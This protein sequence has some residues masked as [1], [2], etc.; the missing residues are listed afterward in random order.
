MPKPNHQTRKKAPVGLLNTFSSLLLQIVTIISGFIIP[1]LILSTFG[2]ETNGLVSSLNQ[3]LNY[4]SLLEGGL[5]SVITASLYKPLIHN[6]QEKISKIV[7]TST[8]FFRRI[9]YIFIAYAVVLA[10]VYP[11][12][13]NSTFNYG[14]VA[15]LTMILAIKL[16]S[17]YC[18]SLSY[19]NLLNTSKR[20][21]IINFSQ[22][23]LIALDVISA[24]VVVKLFPSIHLLKFVS[25]IIFFLQ[26]II[27]R[28]Y[29]NKHFQLD[30][31]VAYDYKLIA[32][33]WDGLSIN[34][35]YFIHSNTDVTLLTLFTDL[36]TVSVYGVYALVTSGLRSIVNSIANGIAPSMGNL[37]AKGDHAEINQKFDLYEYVVF[38]TTFTLF[39]IGGL[40]ITPFVM[41]YTQN[42]TDANYFEPLFGVLFL[43]AE[44]VYVIRNPYVRLAYDAGK[45]KD[46]TVVA[47]SEAAMNILISILLVP[48]FGLVGVAIGTLVAMT[49]RTWYQIWY[50]R[51][52]LIN[53]PFAKFLRRFAAFAI[54][55]IIGAHICVKFWPTTEYTITNWVAHAAIYCIV[56]AI[57][58]AAVSYIFFRN[59]LKTLKAY[60]KHR[61]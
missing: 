33:R 13:A 27:Y 49:F 24:I 48:H 53:R 46:M 45:F 17:Q 42:V 19:K 5:N 37:Y 21:Y 1:R 7:K 9:S 56:F 2:S 47:Y 54:P 36:K 43:M 34:M 51:D 10:L 60:L 26:P 58:Y 23:A 35:A 41:I 39:T 40:L 11:V 6:D 28:H 18:F 22:I 14:F 55:T 15:S 61:H 38:I 4:V 31:N 59:D 50:L 12:L 32:N 20:G 57:I 25:A 8:R 52:H 44:G 29:A 30:N 3:F 16:F